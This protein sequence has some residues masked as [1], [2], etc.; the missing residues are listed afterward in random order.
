[1]NCQRQFDDTVAEVGSL[2]GVIVD[3]A[4]VQILTGEWIGFAF[5]DVCGQRGDILVTDGQMQ[6]HNAVATS[7]GVR[8]VGVFV[9]TAGSAHRIGDVVP[10]V[11]Q[12]SLADG[13]GDIAVIGRIN[14]QRQCGGTVA[15]GL[16]EVVTNQCVIACCGE[17]SVEA[18]GLVAR[19]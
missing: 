6:G 10:G 8:A 5:A 7:C 11:R 3:A 13:E 9:I 1:M 19:S 16:V 14:G 4:L 15:T 18:I 12:C 2:Q 17:Q